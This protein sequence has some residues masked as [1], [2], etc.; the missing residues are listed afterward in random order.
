MNLILHVLWISQEKPKQMENISHHPGIKSSSCEASALNTFAMWLKIAFFQLLFLFHHQ[1][2]IIRCHRFSDVMIML[3][4]PR[5][6][7]F[8]LHP[9][10][11]L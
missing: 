8:S 10:S 2:K 3:R 7:V 1:G 5:I 6:L 9:D 4:F 11:G